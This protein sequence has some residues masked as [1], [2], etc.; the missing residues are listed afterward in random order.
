MPT[1]ETAL[2]YPG[3]C[4]LEGTNLSE[5]RGTTL[6]FQ[7]VGA[8]YLDG[9]RLAQQL[10]EYGV[11]GALVRPYVFRPMFGKHQGAVCQGVMLHVTDSSLFRPVAT[12]TALIALARAQAPEQFE[13][14]SRPYEF[15]TERLAFDLLAGSSSVR[16]AI[17][18]GRSINE[19]VA[20]IS[21]VPAEQRPN[22]AE[23][24]ARALRAS[25]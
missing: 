18:G 5:G 15:E 1:L 20:L 19:I 23:A 25:T 17:L 21:P 3:A 9:M 12:Y 7:T 24:E 22:L 4:L 8:P 10:S 6:P 11:P 13:F 14:L 2:V 16:E